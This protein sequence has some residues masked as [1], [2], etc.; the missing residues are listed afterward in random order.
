[1]N[2]A[3]PASSPETQQVIDLCLSVA[4]GKMEE[5]AALE[6]VVGE[7]QRDLSAASERFFGDIE[8]QPE[9]FQDKFRREIELVEKLFEAYETALAQI[10]SFKANPK[11]ELL[12][13]AAVALSFTSNAM[14]GAMS[15]YEQRVFSEGSHKYPLINLFTNLGASLRSGQ[16]PVEGWVATCKQYR[17]FYEE[18]IQ[19]ID[20]SKHKDDPGVPKRRAAMSK[21]VESLSE[22]EAMDRGTPESKFSQ[23]IDALAEA[24]DEMNSAIAEFNRAA[25]EKP[26]PSPAVNYVILA[27]NSVLA[28][29]MDRDVLKNL[30]NKQLEQVKSSMSELRMLAKN[31]M[32]SATLQEESARMLEGMERMEEALETLVAFAESQDAKPEFAREALQQLEEA[33]LEVHNA[34]QS[35]EGFNERYGKVACPSCGTWNEPSNRS[36]SSCGRQLPQLTGSDVYGGGAST[37]SFQVM[38]GDPDASN[39]EVVMTDVM[40]N[41]IDACEGFEQGKISADEVL[42]LLDAG[43]AHAAEARDELARLAMPPVPEDADEEDRQAA[44]EVV[45]VVHETLRLM[46]MGIE[47][48]EY[49]LAKMRQGVLEESSVA[50]KEGQ[51]HY[52]D[53]CQYMWQVKKVNDRFQSYIQGTDQEEETEA[54]SRGDGLA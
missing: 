27:G 33:T 12:Q 40:K 42:A 11:P 3:P 19:E 53:G 22:L 15:T 46:E 36:C 54:A 45:E 8:K 16:A 21:I 44:E 41:L 2:Q 39:Q 6:G 13:E 51:K 7:R 9:E 4:Q 18:A 32:E 17:L 1:M 43:D 50:L 48:C 24:H 49:G 30:A 52:F 10:L 14:V 23:A 35:V 20:N 5:F 25:I 29:T 34:T 37:S 28:G 38:E 31:P 47:E 26:T